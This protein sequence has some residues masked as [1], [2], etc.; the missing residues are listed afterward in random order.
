MYRLYETTVLEETLNFLLLALTRLALHAK[1]PRFIAVKLQKFDGV[2]DEGDDLGY[3]CEVVGHLLVALDL[4]EDF[5]GL[6]A[7]LEVNEHW[8]IRIL[9]RKVILCAVLDE[10]QRREVHA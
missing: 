2:F 5:R 3:G 1:C 10:N 8:S 9:P 6:M 4:A 7:L